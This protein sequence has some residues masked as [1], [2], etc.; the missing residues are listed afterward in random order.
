[1]TARWRNEWHGDTLHTVPIDDIA[2]HRFEP[3]RKCECQPLTYPATATH[4]RYVVHMAF[5]GREL[6]EQHGVN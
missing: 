6:V 4:R 1:M 5:D 3:L 2:P